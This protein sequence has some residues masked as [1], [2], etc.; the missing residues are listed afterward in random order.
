M[1]Q[2][3]MTEPGRIEFREVREPIPG[4]GEILLRIQQIGICGSDI[5]VNH[6]KHPFTSYPVIQGHEFSGVVEAVGEGI[7]HIRSGTKCTARPQIVCGECGPC[8]RGDYNIC[9][10]LKVE[11]FQAS[12]C[13]QDLFITT[14][15]KI[16][17]L[18]DSMSY[19]QGALVEPTAVAVHATARSGELTG[20]SGVVR[21]SG[22][23]GNLIAQLARCGGAAPILIRDPSDFRLDVARQCGVAAISN[24]G[25][26]SMAEA[27]KRILGDGGFDI[28]F[29]A[30]GVE[31]ALDDAVTG[32]RKGG[33]MVVVGVFDAKPRVDMSVVGDRELNLVGTLMYKHEDYEKA[34]ELIEQGDVI[35]EPLVTRHFP[36]EQYADAYTFIDEQGDQT[37]KVMIDM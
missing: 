18:P 17:P 10:V 34:V 19:E 37:L 7:T 4:P 6:G 23:I 24:S 22:P 11:G 31:A 2:A 1:R 36:F 9:D 3:V 14:V 21:G 8:L 33:T 28:A 30:A 25:T 15:S 20:R 5:H 29:E 35:T 13:A 26:E 27:S 12:G 16:V 32:I